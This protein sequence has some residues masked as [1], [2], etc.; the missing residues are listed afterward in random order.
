MK[1]TSKNSKENLNL[2]TEK[3]L[4]KGALVVNNFVCLSSCVSVFD[5]HFNI[6]LYVC[7]FTILS[8]LSSDLINYLINDL[9]WFSPFLVLAILVLTLPIFRA[10]KLM[11]IDMTL[12]YL[13]KY[14]K[15]NLIRKCVRFQILI[16]KHKTYIHTFNWK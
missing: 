5:G 11:C 12:W 8:S 4:H 14:G 6:K 9:V 7:D 13:K 1:K 16:I 15:A 10:L 2:K 3:G